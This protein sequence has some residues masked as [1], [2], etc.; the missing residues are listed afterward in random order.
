M[1]QFIWLAVL[2]ALITGC[3]KKQEDQ[4]A[5]DAKVAQQARE[6]LLK[7][8]KAKEEAKAKEMEVKK[9]EGILAKAGITKTDD[10][11]IIIDT[12]QTKSYFQ[13]LAKKM[14]TK[15]DKLAQDMQKGMIEEK[16]AGVEVSNEKIV[17]DVNKTK[18]FFEQWAKKMETFVKE[19]DEVARTIEPDNG[20]QGK[21]E[22]K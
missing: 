8:L 6:Q 5:H 22:I 1:K 15:A 19:V 16:E 21:K 18:G 2:L 17:I 14:K 7:E 11:K 12:N 20:S 10:G 4:A 9:E 13:Q 3:D